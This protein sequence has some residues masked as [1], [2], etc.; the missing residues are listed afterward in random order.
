[1]AVGGDELRVPALDEP[2]GQ[3]ARGQPVASQERAGVH[4]QEPAALDEGECEGRSLEHRVGALGVRDHRQQADALCVLGELHKELGRA[5]DGT[6]INTARPSSR[7]GAVLLES[8]G[9]A[10]ARSRAALGPPAAPAAKRPDST[11]ALTR[12]GR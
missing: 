10:S 7:S 9:P 4:L 6:S 5:G 2:P 1:M 3:S 12:G 8:G 11:L